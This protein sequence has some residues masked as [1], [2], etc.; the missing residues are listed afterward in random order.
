MSPK[1]HRMGMIMSN[2]AWENTF[3]G[4]QDDPAFEGKFGWM[5]RQAIVD[6][7][8]QKMERFD[9]R[10]PNPNLKAENFSGGNQQKIAILLVSV[11]LD[12]ILSLSDRVIVMFD[13]AIAGE[14]DAAQT[15]NTELGLLMAGMT[16]DAA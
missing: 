12:E 1:T 3:F 9:I 2:M 16:G 4:Y 8:K 7:A 5:N 10:P 11:E 6:D 13:G 15:D 14:R